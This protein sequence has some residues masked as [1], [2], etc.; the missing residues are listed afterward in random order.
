MSK[1]PARVHT[2]FPNWA[3]LATSSS[4]VFRDSFLFED[5]RYEGGAV[6]HFVLSLSLSYW[7]LVVQYGT[8]WQITIWGKKR[9]VALLYEH[10][11]IELNCSMLA[12]TVERFNKTVN[13]KL[14]TCG[15][16]CL[17]KFSSEK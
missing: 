10:D 3:Q 14:S 15:Q 1:P 12:K 5:L 11:D 16:C 8:S 4:L 2:Q 9:I 6:L 13:G 7:S 17:P